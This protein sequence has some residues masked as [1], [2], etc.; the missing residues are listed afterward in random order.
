[1]RVGP[2]GLVKA[3]GGVRGGDQQRAFDQFTVGR[4]QAEGFVI[5]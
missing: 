1:M 2:G 3:H 5:A 4:E